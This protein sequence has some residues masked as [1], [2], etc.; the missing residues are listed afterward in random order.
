MCQCAGPRHCVGLRRFPSPAGASTSAGNARRPAARGPCQARPAQSSAGSGG[1]GTG[2]RAPAQS[3]R[4]PR[5]S[6]SRVGF[7]VSAGAPDTGA[8]AVAWPV[9]DSEQPAAAEAARQQ[10][11][12]RYG[13]VAARELTQRPV[14]AAPPDALHSGEFARSS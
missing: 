11:H 14:K 6:G 9:G 2:G 13:S 1:P 3:H 4:G 8:T 7:R 5:A 10:P 12:R